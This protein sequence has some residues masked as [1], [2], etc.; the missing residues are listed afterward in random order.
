MLSQWKRNV[1]LISFLSLLAAVPAHVWAVSLSPELV[2]RLRSEG[3]LEE[4]TTRADRARERGVWEAGANPPVLTKSPLT[5]TQIDTVRAIVILV[6]FEDNLHT[7]NP[8]EFDTLLFSKGF[9][10]PTGS[11]RDFFWE[12]SYQGFEVIGDVVGWYRMP[13][14]YVY[15]TCTVGEN[16]FGTYPYNVQKLVEDAVAA[17]D[18]FV[19]FADYDRDGNGFVD[20][21]FVVHAGPGAEETGNDCH[22]WSHRWVTNGYLY[23]DGVK[24]FDYS[25]EPE[26]RAGGTLVDIGVFCHE[27]GHVL[28]LPD[29]YDTDYSSSGLG[30]WSLMAGGSWNNSGRTP[31]HFDA[32][33]KYKLGFVS[34]ERLTSNETDVEIPQ[35]ETS[36]AVYRL[37]TSGALGS[38]YFLVEN[39]QRTGFD[40]Y[41]PGEGLLIYHVD[42]AKSGNT[43]EWCPG[44]PASMHYKVALEQADGFFG[45]EGCYGGATSGDGADPFPGSHNKRAFDDTSAVDSRD[46][47]DNST[48]V[49]AWNISDSDSVMYANLDVTWS[50]PGLSLDQFTMDDLAGG[51]GD[52]RPE[53][54]ETVKL[55]FAISN[56]WLALNGATVTASADTDGVV[57]TDNESYLG[58]IGTGGSADN[59]GDPVEFEVGLSFP[60]RSTIFTLH[61]EGNGGSYSHDFQVEVS[62][63]A[64]EILLADH[65]GAYQSYY[66]DALDT[67]EQVYDV[68]DAYGEADPD[69]SLGQYKYIIWYTGDHTSSLFTQAQ[70]ESLMSF[71]DNGGRLFLTSQDAVEV[72][73]SSQD[74]LFQQFLTDYLHVSYGGNSSELLVAEKAGD[75]I[76]DDMWIFPGGPDSPDNQTSKDNLVPD[77]ETDTVLMYSGIWWEPTNLVAGAKFRNETFRVVVFGFGFEGINSSGQM[78][79]G[80]PVSTPDEVMRK[81][82]DWLK[83]PG[84]TVT[85]TSPNGGENWMAG[86]PYDI[87]WESIS[88]A[89]PVTIEYSAD[90]GGAWTALAAGTSNDGV[91]SWTVPDTPSDICLIR[92][93]D[94]DDGTPADQS[95]GYF[96]ISSYAPGDANAD[97]SVGLGDVIHV[98]N[99]LFKD[100]EP[101]IPPSAG[102]A[103]GNC[104]VNLG[105]ALYLLNYLY[106]N[107]DPPRPGCA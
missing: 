73:A 90:G 99:Y 25:M 76:G 4:W 52:G 89:S 100:G 92:I 88:F 84:P 44:S 40:T 97:G 104:S 38:Q 95:D 37:W 43:Q 64:V 20:A 106:K 85:V 78:Y 35:V 66:T 28:G 72:L 47:Y 34:V 12:N 91:Y 59:Y 93:S 8:A 15:Y 81:V 11:M 18:P 21:V 3:R 101:P 103:N 39:R 31:A 7:R 1:L 102:D 61:V 69:F 50:R 57:F 65:A 16:G 41:I 87:L 19:D 9:I 22:I 27:F 17:A 80:K 56:M 77:S 105:D 55:Y 63:G 23:V 51:D 98:L 82:L 83:A 6:D 33:S 45:L 5:G 67:L 94:M 42:E 10:L 70:V 48:Q 2:E 62:V 54:G 13:Q 86:Q 53:G 79:Y 24:I 29:L 32:W 107:G 30:R 46:Y 68:W 60:G 96:S 26:R 58:D 74:P 14:D 71:L 49:A 36:P 75:E